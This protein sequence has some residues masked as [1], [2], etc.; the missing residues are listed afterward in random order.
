MLIRVQ[1][2]LV[3][4]EY[5]VS[6]RYAEKFNGNHDRPTVWL[7]M[8]DGDEFI[9]TEGAQQFWNYLYDS[10]VPVTTDSSGT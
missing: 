4:P 5:I 7:K 1:N 6:A 10:A 8:L 3:N 9:V 2:K